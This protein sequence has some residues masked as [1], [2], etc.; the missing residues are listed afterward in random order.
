MSND[1]IPFS[2]DLFN[3][4]F[5][6]NEFI[7]LTGD[8]EYE[9]YDHAKV[10]RDG[11]NEYSITD[12]NGYVSGGIKFNEMEQ[13]FDQLTAPS[14]DKEY[15]RIV[16]IPY[17][18]TVVQKTDH[19]ISNKLLL[20]ERQKISD[21]AIWKYENTYKDHLL[22]KPALIKYIKNVSPE[23]ALQ[24]VKKQPNVIE[25]IENQTHEM[26]VIVLSESPHLFS[27]I[28]FPTYEMFKEVIK[29]KSHF[30]HQIRNQISE[31]QL[32]EL[33]DINN[34]VLVALQY[35]LQSIPYHINFKKYVVSKNGLLLE[36]IKLQTQEICDIAFEN[37]MLS[38]RYIVENFKTHDMCKRVLEYDIKAFHCIPQ[39]F[40][41]NE[42]CLEYIKLD[43]H[44]IHQ[45]VSPTDEMY[46][47]ASKKIPSVLSKVRNIALLDGI[48][49]ISIIKC[50][51]LHIK[52]IVSPTYE[53]YF[54]AVK[55]NGSLLCIV[56]KE[57]MN[58]EIAMV[59]V[60]KN[61]EAIKYVP[62]QYKEL[63]FESLNQDS[64][65]LAHIRIK[66]MEIYEFLILKDL[67]NIKL[68]QDF[69][70][71]ADITNGVDDDD[72]L[73]LQ[74]YCVSKNGMLLSIVD[75]QNY[76]MCEIAINDNPNAIRFVADDLLDSDLC[77]LAFAK[78]KNTFKNIK[79]KTL[80]MCRD[81][82][83]ENPFNIKYIEAGFLTDKMC[84]YAINKNY[85]V[86]GTIK[87]QTIEM[88]MFAVK[89]N[90][91]AIN[92]VHNL[93]ELKAIH[94]WAYNYRVV[95]CIKNIRV[96]NCMMKSHNELIDAR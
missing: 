44:L 88:C 10:L 7:K 15:F 52:N 81:A 41:N 69:N 34:D 2:G 38:F 95:N 49:P 61:G 6:Q 83:D 24:L 39:K 22:K 40:M 25:H 75:N 63:C 13:L 54:E 29:N 23:I 79:F 84:L 1:C 57:M 42:L 56:P 70:R 71:H 26:C 80:I 92:H 20:F 55:G 51:P 27:K 19:Y 5:G 65:N 67:N 76:D 14:G 62:N 21:L 96:K 94:L 16:K 58:D 91:M 93:T 3:E 86:L 60:K 43:P 28:H 17:D 30:I 31:E 66:N 18:A 77:E 68:I 87:E 74:M 48:D 82:I 59:G 9:G 33:F 50:N 72:M 78:D 46:M 37:N 90:P 4:I 45:I 36:L 8:P 12:T 64:K 89:K 32:Y 11:I 35:V 53:M 85:K 47:E 73:K